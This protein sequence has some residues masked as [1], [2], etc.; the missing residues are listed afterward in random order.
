MHCSYL[1]SNC[2]ECLFQSLFFEKLSPNQLTLIEENHNAR[3][4]KKGEIVCAQGE[5]VDNF[6]FLRSGLIKLYSTDE[7]GNVRII[8]LAKPLDCLGLM[9]VFSNKTYLYSISAIEDSLVCFVPVSVLRSIIADNGAFALCFLEKISSVNDM[10]LQT[11]I[12]L[13][14]KQLR[15]KIA[16]SLLYFSQIVYNSQSFELP[17]SRKEIGELIDVRTENVI[18]VLSE[19]RNED[20]INTDGKQITIKNIEKLKLLSKHG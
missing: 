4:Y 7:A 15:G 6:M 18:R 3:L 13:S 12:E 14:Q 20:I 11:R 10:V 9:S 16:H 8:S 2:S 5:L 17:V 1:H 19:F